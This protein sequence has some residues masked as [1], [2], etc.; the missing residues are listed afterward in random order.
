M[1]AANK[2]LDIIYKA[3]FVQI[4]KRSL[5]KEADSMRSTIT[6]PLK[7]QYSLLF[8]QYYRLILIGCGL[9]IFQQLSGIIIAVQYGPTLIQE[10]GF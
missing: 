9:M 10:A 3:Q 8:T 2:C 6:L 5:Q 1:I 7:K 4:Y